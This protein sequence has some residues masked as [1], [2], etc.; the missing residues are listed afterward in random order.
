MSLT[1]RDGVPGTEGNSRAQRF[2]PGTFQSVAFENPSTILLTEIPVFR[3]RVPVTIILE[4]PATC[5]KKKDRLKTAV[6]VP[7]LQVLDCQT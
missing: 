5:C 1:L 6:G 7:K 4:F 2:F 3:T